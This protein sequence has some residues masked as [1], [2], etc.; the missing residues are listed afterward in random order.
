MHDLSGTWTSS[1]S[2]LQ[3]VNGQYTHSMVNPC[4]PLVLTQQVHL[5]R[6]EPFQQKHFPGAPFTSPLYGNM[7][8]RYPATHVLGKFHPGEGS[9]ELVSSGYEVIPPATANALKNSEDAVVK[10]LAMT[11]KEKIEKLRRRQQMRAILAIQKQ[12]LQFGNQGSVSEHSSMEGGKIEVDESLGSFPSL[13]ANSPI[14]QDDSNTISMAFDNCSVEESVLYRLQDTIAKLDIR[15]RLCIRDS[16]FRLAQ[17]ATQRQY[18]NDTS[19]TSVSG[20][21]EVLGNKDTV[22]HERFARMP[23]VETDTNPIDRTVAHLLFHRPLEFTGKPAETPESPASANL[24]Y[25]RKANSSKSLA[26]G[27]FPETFNNT[28]MTSPQGPKSPVIFSEGDQS[29]NGPSFLTSDNASNNENID[30]GQTKIE[31]SK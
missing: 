5:P 27:Y 9:H 14:E 8:N 31:T 21:D 18:P 6:P 19:S 13:E 12:Q 3:H 30:V 28:L 29:K 11:P 20:R 2:P 16:L 26:K 1:G 4:P 23:D 24:P 10:P 15:I 17:S 22:S 25:E 7:V